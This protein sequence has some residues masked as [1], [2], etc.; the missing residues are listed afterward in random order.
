MDRMEVILAVFQQFKNN[1]AV[2]RAHSKN[3]T[4][5][6]LKNLKTII[7]WSNSL[8]RRVVGVLF[9]HCRQIGKWG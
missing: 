5:R 3:P 1:T 7:C 9:H 6:V 4:M 2:M 8:G